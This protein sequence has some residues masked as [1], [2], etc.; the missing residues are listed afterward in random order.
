MFRPEPLLQKVPKKFLVDTSHPFCMGAVRV[1]YG[2]V[3]NHRD[4]ALQEVQTLLNGTFF[5]IDKKTPDDNL[6]VTEVAVRLL[7][8]GNDPGTVAT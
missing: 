1:T 4:I 6:L 8:T 7:E 3:V 5:V 2:P